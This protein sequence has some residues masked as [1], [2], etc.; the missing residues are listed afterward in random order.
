MTNL[1]YVDGV[2]PRPFL[3]RRLWRLVI[4]TLFSRDDAE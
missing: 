3:W 1:F 2:S 4:W